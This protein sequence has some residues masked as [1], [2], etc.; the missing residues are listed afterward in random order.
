M[1]EELNAENSVKQA[2]VDSASGLSSTPVDN[3]DLLR[4]VELPVTLCFGRRKMRLRE[5]LENPQRVDELFL[6]RAMMRSSE[7]LYLLAAEEKF[8]QVLRLEEANE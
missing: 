6:E 8:E 4:G 7:K 1:S 5:V 2:V 3:I